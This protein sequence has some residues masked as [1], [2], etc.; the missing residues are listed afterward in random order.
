MH[1]YMTREGKRGSEIMGDHSLKR[2]FYAQ[3][4]RLISL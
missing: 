2:G 3:R 1:D 4:T